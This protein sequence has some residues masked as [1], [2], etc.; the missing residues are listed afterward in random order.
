MISFVV[1]DKITSEYYQI[2]ITDGQR[3]FVKLSTFVG[4]LSV[5]VIADDDVTYGNW[6]YAISDGQEI[7]VTNT[8]GTAGTWQLQDPSDTNILWQIKVNQGQLYFVEI[9]PSGTGRVFFYY[10][11]LLPETVGLETPIPS[12]LTVGILV[13]GTLRTAKHYVGEIGTNV[14]LNV[15]VD[16]SASTAA[17]IHVKKPDGTT[18]TW[19]PTVYTFN[20]DTFFLKYTTTTGDFD[21]VG[22]YKVQPYVVLPDWKGYGKTSYFLIY[23]LF[24]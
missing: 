15:G 12:D 13:G 17:E 4:T 22:K 2:S 16:I 18:V 21:Q 19:S 11:G 23:P 20:G 3:T 8:T 9:T 24:G 14:I 1:Q 7:I 5:P 10:D 6:E